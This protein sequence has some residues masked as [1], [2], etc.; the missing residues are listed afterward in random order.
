MER[1]TELEDVAEVDGQDIK[2]VLLLEEVNH[3]GLASL[4]DDL[5][6][7]DGENVHGQPA[8]RLAHGGV[9]LVEGVERHVNHAPV[10]LLEDGDLLVND[11]AVGVGEHETFADGDESAIHMRRIQV[12]G[13]ME[14]ADLDALGGEMAL[15]PADTE[16]VGDHRLLHVHDVTDEHAIGGVEHDLVLVEAESV[17]VHLLLALLLG[18]FPELGSV[19]VVTHEGLGGGG[20]DGAGI[21]VEIILND[22]AEGAVLEETRALAH[23]AF[24]N[25]VTDGHQDVTRA[26]DAVLVG[27]LPVGSLGADVELTEGLVRADDLGA[28][29]FEEVLEVVQL[30]VGGIDEATELRARGP[31]DVLGESMRHLRTILGVLVVVFGPKLIVHNFCT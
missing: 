14:G 13:E 30:H 16:Q 4:D 10:V 22:G 23:G 7:A 29:T 19:G 9:L 15:E 18:P 24:D 3:L 6:L 2:A 5:V 25:F 31:R 21:T 26:D 8:G 27:G 11:G 28:L 1:A 20:P 12:V 17:V